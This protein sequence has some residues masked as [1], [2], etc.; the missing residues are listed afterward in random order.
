MYFCCTYAFVLVAT[1]HISF[2]MIAEF[3]RLDRGENS[4]AS[5]HVKNMVFY[6]QVD[7]A[8]LKGDVFACMKKKHQV[9]VIQF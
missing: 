8:L 4:Y 9:E 3:F 1:N 2:T 5:G 7:P 6:P